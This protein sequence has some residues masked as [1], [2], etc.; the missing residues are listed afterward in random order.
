MARDLRERGARVALEARVLAQHERREV[1][2]RAGVDGGL[3]ELRAVLGDVAERRGGGAL[4]GELRLL[5][6]EHEQRQ[7]AG[8]GGLAR[9]VGRVAGDVAEAPAR[10][11]LSKGGGLAA[12]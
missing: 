6:A 9:E 2:D 3:R 11:L 10:G 4:Q 7:R 5:H 1:R 8:V 12:W